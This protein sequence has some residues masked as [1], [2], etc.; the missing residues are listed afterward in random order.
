MM[1]RTEIIVSSHSDFCFGVQRAL[2]IAKEALKKNRIVY[3]VG[4]IIHNPQVVSEFSREG[5]K[6]INDV[7]EICALRAKGKSKKINL[8]IPSHGISPEV[9]RKNRI[10]FIDTT[11]PLVE[12]VQRIVRDLSRKGY[13]IIIVGDKKHPEVRG[14]AGIAGKNFRVLKNKREAKA[15][16]FPQGASAPA[17]KK[18]KRIALISQ[19][20]A[21]VSNFKE[22]F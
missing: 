12:R 6:I 17:E 8:L 4:P 22:I 1:R 5:L 3:S 2:N 14:L 9:L 19:T 13:F 15:F 18:L 21:P 11:C 20:T 10:A 16:N 7:K